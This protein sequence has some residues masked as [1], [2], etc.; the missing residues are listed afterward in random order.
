MPA[1]FGDY[2]RNDT[3]RP[4]RRESRT[5]DRVQIHTWIPTQHKKELKAEAAHRGTTMN[6]LVAG[7]IERYL[8]G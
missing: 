3:P 5:V 6:S 2:S 7:L 4:V 1:K 8:Y